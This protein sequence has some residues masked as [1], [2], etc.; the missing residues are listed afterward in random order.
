MPNFTSKTLNKPLKTL[1]FPRLARKADETATTDTS[2]ERFLL[3]RRQGR[4]NNS[5][6][7]VSGSPAAALEQLPHWKRSPLPKPRARTAIPLKKFLPKPKI[8]RQ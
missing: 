3:S 4:T 5:D 8:L 7:P 6:R 1:S 2:K